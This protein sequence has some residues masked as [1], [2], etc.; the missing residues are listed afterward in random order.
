MSGIWRGRRKYYQAWWANAEGEREQGSTGKS[1]K[2]A[3]IQW[4]RNKELEASVRRIP[5]ITVGR[6]LE[7]DQ[8]ARA[9]CV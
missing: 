4:L 1:T 6:A 7:R 3:A 9:T 8:V 2:K 5:A